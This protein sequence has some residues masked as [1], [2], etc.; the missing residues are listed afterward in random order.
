MIEHVGDLDLHPELG[1][2]P[3]DDLDGLQGLAPSS[4]KLS[5]GAM[6]ASPRICCQ[7]AP[8]RFSVSLPR[9][10]ASPPAW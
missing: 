1:A 4:K 2:E 10:R 5:A 3:V 8:T 6:V 7:M 9:V